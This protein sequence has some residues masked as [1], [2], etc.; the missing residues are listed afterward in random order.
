M[1]K[2]KAERLLLDKL[3]GELAPAEAA[4]LEHYLATHP[5]AAERLTADGEMLRAY[6]RLPRRSPPAGAAL[7]ALAAA[8]A[9]Q[10]T[11]R[12]EPL[13]KGRGL[14]FSPLL[15]AAAAAV[16]ICT[17]IY[18]LPPKEREAPRSSSDSCEAQAAKCGPT[19]QPS[20]GGGAQDSSK[21]S[22]RLA[23]PGAAA[24][25]KM[26]SETATPVTPS[27][28]SEAPAPESTNAENE[29]ADSVMHTENRNGGGVLVPKV[30]IVIVAQP[31]TKNA[32]AAENPA[33]KKDW[34][35]MP[36]PAETGDDDGN[37]RGL[38]APATTP[39]REAQMFLDLENPG[40]G[41]GE[42][43]AA[44][45]SMRKAE[46]ARKG[47]ADGQYADQSV[48][49]VRDSAAAVP[50][51][52]A[53]PALPEVNLVKPYERQNLAADKT[54]EQSSLEKLRLR[55]EA[56]LAVEDARKQAVAKAAKPVA[57]TERL[58]EARKLY[59][60]GKYAEAL[61]L[62]DQALA[63]PTA[64]NDQATRVSLL[65]LKGNILAKLNR[66]DEAL[67]AQQEA[68]NAIG[69]LP[70]AKEGAAELPGTTRTGK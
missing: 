42:F 54:T 10:P 18:L 59:A 14:R 60:A 55:A 65:A 61:T 64:A 7:A 53:A 30:K 26:M 20:A 29:A 58:A 32:A 4:E 44:P 17:V 63:A 13:P 15:G 16:T 68:A 40:K 12:L 50:A 48:A 35:E 70:S 5:D 19:A 8:R 24:D 52:P 27:D 67:A 62:T 25:T 22:E 47:K 21:A 57:L 38:P 23:A 34:G 43:P 11:L 39:K 2:E 37:A 56:E 1:D 9:S 46:E 45:N 41:Q 36:R 3:Y 66:I 6:R 31:E 49:P 28:K 69:G 33:D 51:N